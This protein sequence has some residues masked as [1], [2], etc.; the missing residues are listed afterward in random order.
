MI[1]MPLKCHHIE[2]CNKNYRKIDTLKRILAHLYSSTP[3]GWGWFFLI[4]LIIIYK[5]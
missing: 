3:E 2:I 1:N 5:E 4:N